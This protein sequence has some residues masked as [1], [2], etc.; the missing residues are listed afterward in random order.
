[1]I[2]PIGLTSWSEVGVVD[3]NA[4]HRDGGDW[5]VMREVEKWDQ[6]LGGLLLLCISFWVSGHTGRD[7]KQRASLRSIQLRWDAGADDTG[8]CHQHIDETENIGKIKQ[9]RK[10]GSEAFHHFFKFWQKR[11]K[12]TERGAGKGRGK[13]GEGGAMTGEEGKA[14]QG[15]NRWMCPLLLQT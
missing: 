8:L 12:E 1:M 14:G 15:G 7:N 5:G 9:S 4:S 13:A 11:A 3:N 10:M 2:K 6:W